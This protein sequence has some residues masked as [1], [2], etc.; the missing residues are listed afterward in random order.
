MKIVRGFDEKTVAEIAKECG[1]KSVKGSVSFLGAPY[2]SGGKGFVCEVFDDVAFYAGTMCKKH[3]R[4]YEMAVRKDAQGR[5]YG[6]AMV[7][8]MKALCAR[9]GAEKIT[10]RTSREETAIEFYGRVGGVITGSKGGDY[11]VEIFV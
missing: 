3:F 2:I 1:S 7:A 5:G 8:R 6:T 4:L 10:L 9:S 11:E